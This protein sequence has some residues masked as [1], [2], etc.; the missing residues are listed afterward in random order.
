M[1]T[2][3]NGVNGSARPAAPAGA[4]RSGASATPVARSP[5]PTRQRRPGYAALGALLVLGLGGGFGYLYS[6]AGE[7]VPAV[8][9]AQPVAVGEVIE[10]SDLSTV[11]VAGDITAI[12]GE[13]LQS[14]VGQRAAVALLPDTLLQ[15]SMVTDADP[16]PAGQVQV[17]VAVK[18]GQL[19]ADGLIPGDRVQVLALPGA[20]KTGGDAGKPVVLAGAA[21]VFAA[22]P[23]PVQAGG[24][25][26]TLLVPAADGPAVAVAGASG[27]AALVKVPAL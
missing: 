6:T 27:S 26:L 5:L 16:I 15:R 12:A 14:V 18:G 21:V 11:D 3:V 7:K 25:L 8:V 22:R 20:Q 13:N 9:V 2:S 17:G 1:T 4:A 10:R 19:P 23:D 24:T